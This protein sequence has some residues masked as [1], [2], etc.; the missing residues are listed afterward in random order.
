VISRG[1]L[2]FIGL[3]LLALL[4]TTWWGSRYPATVLV[5]NQAAT[6]RDVTLTTSGRAVAIGELRRGES[7]SVRVP[8]GDYITL[9][10]RSS[11]QRHWTSIEKTNPAQSVAI[12]ISPEERVGVKSGLGGR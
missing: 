2:W 1:L 12:T 4:A 11:R 7:R 10:F 3:A 8:S 6:L 9:D 5:M